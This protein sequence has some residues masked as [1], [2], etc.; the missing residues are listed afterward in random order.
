[1]ASRRH[2]SR[3]LFDCGSLSRT[4]LDIRAGVRP[5]FSFRCLRCASGVSS[6][7]SGGLTPLLD[8]GAVHDGV[9][10][11]RQLVPNDLGC[12]CPLS[13][14]RAVVAGDVVGGR[15]VAVLD[16]DLHVVEPGLG[17]R[18]KAVDPMLWPGMPWQ[19]GS[20]DL[21][22]LSASVSP[23]STS[24]GQRN[25]LCSSRFVN[26]HRP[27]S[28]N[29]I[30]IR[31][32]L[33]P[34]NTNRWPEKGSCRSTPWIS[35][36]SPSIVAGCPCGSGKNFKRCHGAPRNVALNRAPDLASAARADSGRFYA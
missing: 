31:L 33:L 5:R 32:A 34:R 17:E 13:G 22:E 21:S 3:G 4:R 15:G 29:T 27:P 10:G 26:R 20:S 12:E 25:T 1:M 2:N 9:H 18:A 8:V 35:M 30:L 6:G 19:V 36:V 24:G 16:G 23:G 14:K 11:E 7:Q 28:Q